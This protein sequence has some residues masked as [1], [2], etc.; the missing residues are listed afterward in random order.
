MS[1]RM[2]TRIDPS[3][4]G[5]FSRGMYGTTPVKMFTTIKRWI[6]EDLVKYEQGFN[7]LVRKDLA[8]YTPVRTGR[9]LDTLLN[10]LRTE[11][12]D[13]RIRFTT[14]RPPGYPQLIQNPQHSYEI[15]WGPKYEPTN[16]IKNRLVLKN[17]PK[18]AYYVLNDPLAI[19]DYMSIINLR[20]IPKMKHAIRNLLP[21]FEV[22]FVLPDRGKDKGVGIGGGDVTMTIE[23]KTWGEKLLDQWDEVEYHSDIEEGDS[24]NWSQ[25]LL[26]KWSKV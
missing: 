13:G 24:Y 2:R 19:P 18:G 10:N 3:A 8:A 1:H 23:R 17:T 4:S 20:T 22:R 26:D 12:T 9:L 5:L 7:E 21:Y 15:G 6:F 25:D 11:V 14:D 16:P